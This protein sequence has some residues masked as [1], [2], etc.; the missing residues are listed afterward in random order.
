MSD[1][2]APVLDDD[3]PHDVDLSF[4]AEYDSTADAI[5]EDA[6][7]ECGKPGIG[8]KEEW[9]TGCGFYP[10]LGI[11]IEVDPDP[12]ET[13]PAPETALD[14]LKQTPTWVPVLLGGLV[15]I[16][17]VSVAVRLLIPVENIARPI[18][19]ISQYMVGM[20]VFVVV[21][22]VAYLYAI[23]EDSTL[24]VADIFLR[25]LK[26]WGPTFNALPKTSR[27]VCLGIWGWA[28]SALALSVVGGIPYHLLWEMGPEE[29]AKVNLV[30][31]ITEQARSVEGDAESLEDAIEDF[32]GEAGDLDEEET[33]EADL[34][35][36]PVRDRR[37]DCLII[38]Y[39]PDNQ[40]SFLSLALGAVRRGKLQYVGSVSNKYIAPEIRDEMMK[41]MEQ[42]EQSNPF[43]KSKS[44]KF[45]WLAPKLTCRIGYNAWNTSGRLKEV[46]FE[47]RLGDLAN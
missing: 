27:R 26:V 31:A 3:Q 40:G 42:I 16:L 38:G 24:S 22:I 46:V 6:C 5:D 44:S 9:C 29:Q 45:T 18:W 13:Q 37:I 35:E 12:E 10:R 17:L 25:P 36:A 1:A 11:T 21:H 14:V 4:E 34:Y 20:F 43:V 47:K 2:T 33:D 41:T 28:A 30:Q 19:A 8:T 32:T 39:E 23:I 7:P 15:V